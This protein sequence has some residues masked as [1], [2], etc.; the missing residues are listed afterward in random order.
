MRSEKKF[1]SAVDEII[2]RAPVET[3]FLSQEGPEAEPFSQRFSPENKIRQNQAKSSTREVL[4]SE[5]FTSCTAVILQAPDGTCMFIHAESGQ[6]PSSEPVSAARKFI[7][8]HPGTQMIIIRSDIAKQSP[9]PTG[10]NSA[11]GHALLIEEKVP[12]IK[13][14]EA[15]HGLEGF[16]VAYD[17]AADQI[18]YC[19]RFE[20]QL[21]AFKG[22]SA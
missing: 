10:F 20:G 16:D 7:Q 4:W 1:R 12:L 3:A 2:A 13:I 8:E 6:L 14:I 5:K 19:Q 21:F 9:M 18:L 15:A 22:F 17:P 11:L